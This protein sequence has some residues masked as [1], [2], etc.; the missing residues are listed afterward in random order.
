MPNQRRKEVLK[1]PLETWPQFLDYKKQLAS[2]KANQESPAMTMPILLQP[3]AKI[4]GKLISP[5][6]R[7]PVSDAAIHVTQP[8]TEA[9]RV[10]DWRSDQVESDENGDY[11][12]GV[13]PN[14]KARISINHPNY[15]SIEQ[16]FGDDD[17]AR[18][19]S[20]EVRS[21][22]HPMVLRD[23]TLTESKL[24]ARVFE[25]SSGLADPTLP[26]SSSTEIESKTAS[27][28]PDGE[29]EIAVVD[30]FGDPT[31]VDVE[32]WESTYRELGSSTVEPINRPVWQ[33]AK[34]LTTESSIRLDITPNKRQCIVAKSKTGLVGFVEFNSKSPIEQNRLILKLKK[35]NQVSGS[36]IDYDTGKPIAGATLSVASSSPWQRANV[37]RGKEVTTDE[38]GKFKLDGLIPRMYT[39]I[40]VT[41]PKNLRFGSV[42]KDFEQQRT[43]GNTQPTV[44]EVLSESTYQRTLA[45]ARLSLPSTE[46]LSPRESLDLILAQFE[47]R[48]IRAPVRF[49]NPKAFVEAMRAKPHF[50]YLEAVRTIADSAKSNLD[51]QDNVDV[52]F[53]ALKWLLDQYSQYSHYKN[54]GVSDEKSAKDLGSAIADELVENH[55]HHPRFKDAF[56]VVNRF[57]RPNDWLES[58][59]KDHP[60]HHVQ[61]LAAIELASRNATIVPYILYT[62][63]KESDTNQL[64]AKQAKQRQYAELVL[65]K[66][67][68]VVDQGY[69]KRTLDFRARGMIKVLDQF[70]IGQKPPPLSGT[71][72][73]GGN[74]STSDFGNKVFVI[75]FVNFSQTKPLDGILPMQ[76]LRHDFADRLQLIGFLK[77][78]KDNKQSS[79]RQIS[80]V[81][82]DWPFLWEEIPNMHH[83]IQIGGGLHWGEV[84]VAALQKFHS[85][86]IDS[87]GKIISMGLKGE[88][89]AEFVRSH[90]DGSE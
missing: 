11:E 54:G 49:R 77:C 88:P 9:G 21:L 30:A 1:C 55:L 29:V 44:I 75:H 73:A 57:P 6:T 33:L 25:E 41:S 66:Y 56:S 63:G 81:G 72:L 80:D 39:R 67:S 50:A 84:Q 82:I 34:Q 78:R 28:I 64:A 51:N 15:R 86:V 18:L 48:K 42:S 85:M 5:T 47:R 43:N 26:D 7:K 10:A 65:E 60:D 76:N 68:D 22:R 24:T 87:D 20:S 35:P 71:T 27:E 61:G 23:S 79:Q 13:I 38:S 32:F 59:L 89:L 2:E 12:I 8:L 74:L 19:Q 37:V 46:N 14:A 16:V 52:W 3:I 45:A 53:D 36:V 58:L 69:S 62:Q 83:G 17:S 31:L 4:K 90:L 40:T 70:G